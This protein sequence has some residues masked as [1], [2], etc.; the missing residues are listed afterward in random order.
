MTG[1]LVSV[2]DAAEA[3][4]ALAGGADLIDVKEPNAGSLGAAKPE[5]IADVIRAVAGRRSVSAALGELREVPAE[6]IQ[7]FAAPAALANLSYVKIGLAGCASIPDWAARWELSL[8]GF[9][10]SVKTVAVAY[11]DWQAADA[12][13]PDVVIEIGGQFGCSALLIDTFDKQRPGL[14]AALP[15]AE[16]ARIVRAGRAVRMTVVLGGRIGPDDFASLLPLEPDYLAVR[17]AVCRGGRE[18]RLDQALVRQVKERLVK[19]SRGGPHRTLSAL[20]P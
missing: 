14:L 2:R 18:S 20:S 4:D 10:N 6:G 5:V 16:L 13:P 15:I 17:G 3:R 11:A 8:R 19:L 1:L 12:P 9:R 7:H